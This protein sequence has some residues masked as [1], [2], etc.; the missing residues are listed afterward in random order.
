MLCSMKWLVTV[1]ASVDLAQLRR[2]LAAA[3]ATIED[4][5]A[6]PL[7]PPVRA[8]GAADDA[9]AVVPAEGPA[10][11]PDRLRDSPIALHVYP[12]S[13]LELFGSGKDLI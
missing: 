2:E 4:R 1:R 13:E 7:A 10:D 12:D 11:L 6:I 3:E 9:E 5:P 8:D